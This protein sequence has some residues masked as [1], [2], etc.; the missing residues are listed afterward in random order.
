M[1][2]NPSTK[3]QAEMKSG[4]MSR[5]KVSRS[6]QLSVRGAVERLELSREGEGG[7]L[8]RGTTAIGKGP[9]GMLVKVA[10]WGAGYSV[11]KGKGKEERGR[12][13]GGIGDASEGG[14]TES[15]VKGE[16]GGES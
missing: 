5:S 15:V 9:V 7:S 14:T 2:T 6:G 3:C 10:C 4:G 1:L 16:E 12:G 11:V 8:G 13:V